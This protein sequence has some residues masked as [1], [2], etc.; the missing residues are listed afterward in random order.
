[1][2]QT[3]PKKI[4][5]EGSIVLRFGENVLAASNPVGVSEMAETLIAILLVTKSAGGSTLV[6]RWPEHPAPLPRLSRPRPDETLSLSLLDN[7]WKASHYG[8]ELDKPLDSSLYDFSHDPNYAWPRPNAL[9]GRTLSF[10]HGSHHF[11]GSNP[12]SGGSYERKDFVLDEYEHVL[13]YS[14]EFL[15][16]HLCPQESMCHQKFELVIDDLAFIGH[17]VCAESDGGW[18]F[19]PEKI[20]TGS[21]GR[22]A[23]DIDDPL[24]PEVA[25]RNRS[26]SE[27]QSASGSNWLHTF[28]LV[29][30]LDLPD[31]SS[32]VS[33]NLSKYFNI[34]YEQIGFTLTAVLYQEQ[35]LSNFVERE[36]DALFTLKE[37]CIS[38]GSQSL[39]IFYYTI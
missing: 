8:E 24:S 2:K 32:S 28:H 9:R 16:Q 25:T 37:S 38:K 5:L 11:S 10:G 29:L 13:G 15:A 30:V 31:P 1:M 36:C 22:G 26:L 12:P 35:V 33:G 3:K 34:L 17:P 39:S 6:F 27:S 20:R 7:P 23:R 18:R 19:K 14:A 4:E 21:R